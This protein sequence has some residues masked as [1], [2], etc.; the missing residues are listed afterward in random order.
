MNMKNFIIEHE[1]QL[2]IVADAVLNRLQ[3]KKVLLLYGDLASG[4]T[5]LVKYI[6][7]SLEI[8]DEASSPTF[9]VMNEYGND[10]KVYHYDI[11]QDGSEKFI[12]SNLWQNTFSDGVHIIEW[13]D[14]RV[15]NILNSVG[16]GFVKLEIEKQSDNKRIFKLYE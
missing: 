16:I 1:N 8:H 12:S 13:P 6:L 11:Y 3:D 10:V 4:K 15:E 5:T 9:S 14:D 7:E 2:Q